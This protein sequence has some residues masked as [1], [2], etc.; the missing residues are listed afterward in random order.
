V[1]NCAKPPTPLLID[2]DHTA[3]IEAYQAGTSIGALAREYGVSKSTISLVIDKAGAA[4][5][6]RPD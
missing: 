6:P 5:S 1:Q 3:I 2:V 4:P